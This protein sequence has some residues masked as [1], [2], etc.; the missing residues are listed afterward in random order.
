MN[1]IYYT[2]NAAYVELPYGAKVVEAKDYDNL[3]SKFEALQ[4]RLNAVE[5]ENDR[6]RNQVTR[7]LPF[8]SDTPDLVQNGAESLAEE[9]RSHSPWRP[10]YGPNEWGT[11][12]GKC[13]RC[14][15]EKRP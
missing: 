4:L 7:A 1:V 5:E 14:A 15:M 13:D 3:K 12:C 9:I 6:L 8:L 2:S 10:C 11:E